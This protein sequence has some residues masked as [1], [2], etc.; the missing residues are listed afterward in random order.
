MKRKIA[1]TIAAK[2]FALVLV[3]GAAW[4]AQAQ[5][6]KA[7][8]LTMA[9]V[10]QYLMVDRNTEIALARRAAPVAISNDAEVLVLGRHGYE[11]AVRGKNGFI[12]LVERAWGSPFDSPE[13]WNPKIRAP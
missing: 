1:K 2:G 13:F 5:D 9:P 4:Q 12:C 11:T 3:L 7:P 10:G 6:A 8:Y